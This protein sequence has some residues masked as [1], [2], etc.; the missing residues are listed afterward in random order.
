M[1]AVDTNFELDR[2]LQ[3][4]GATKPEVFDWDLPQPPLSDD[5]LFCLGYMMDIESHTIV[6]LRELLSTSIVCEA[7]VTAFLSCWVYEEFFHSLLLRR[8]LASQGVS[9][10]DRRFA[11]LRRRRSLADFILVPIARLGSHL[12]R[13]FPAVHMTWGA[14]NEIST[15]TGYQAVIRRTDPGRAMGGEPT[16]LTTILERII[17]DERRHFA[18]YFNQARMRLKP[19]TAQRL[20]SFSLRRFWTP[21]GVSVRGDTSMRRVCDFLFP[22]DGGLRALS[23]VDATIRKLPGL[24]WFNLGR[25]YAATNQPPHDHS[26]TAAWGQRTPLSE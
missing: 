23:E 18:F 24:E 8:F 17:K 14:I 7:D 26:L 21:V 2:Y 16:L 20:A 13:H 22:D 15:L 10:E 25:R 4:S 5:A 19:R 3:V 12:T 1:K 9:I 6:Y 11:D